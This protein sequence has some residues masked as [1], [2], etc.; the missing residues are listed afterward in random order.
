MHEK[1]YY[2]LYIPSNNAGKNII[3]KSFNILDSDPVRSRVEGPLAFSRY[4]GQANFPY[5]SLENSTNRFYTKHRL[6]S[7]GTKRAI[8]PSRATRFRR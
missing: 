1:V 2:V 4:P 8:T 5:I 7:A 3:D 6:G